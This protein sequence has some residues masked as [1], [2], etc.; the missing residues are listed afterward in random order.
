LMLLLPLLLPGE[1]LQR[2]QVV[3]DAVAGHILIISYQIYRIYNK[4]FI[5]YRTKL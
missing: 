3:V 2:A 4:F 5:N 1:A